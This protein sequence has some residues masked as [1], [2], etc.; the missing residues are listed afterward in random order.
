MIKRTITA[1]LLGLV[2]S[3]WVVS[4]SAQPAGPYA[5][6]Q[7]REI[8]GLSPKEIE[9]P[10]QARGMGLAKP[11]ELNSYPGPLHA[12]ELAGELQL[13]TEQRKSLEASKARMAAQAKAL[14]AE[15]FDL[16]RKLDAAFC[17][18]CFQATALSGWGS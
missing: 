11:A 10:V 6:Q 5:G 17:N 2:M 9:D 3:G 12:L 4:V 16:E 15:I 8:K 7:S 14:G 1:Q 13:S 18:R